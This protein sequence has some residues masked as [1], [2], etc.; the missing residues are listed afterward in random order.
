[1]ILG[2]TG[3]GKELF[4]QS[5]HNASQRKN[6]PLCGHQLRGPAESVGERAVRL[7]GGAFT[8]RP[9]AGKWVCSSRPGGTLFWTRLGKSPGHPDQ[10]AACPPGAGGAAI[11]DDK[12]I[13]VLRII[14]ATNKNLTRLTGRGIL[15]GI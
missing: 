2:E 3:T 12:V 14:S 8:G 7:R 13:S 1:M 11:G 5:I 10:A 9:R 6:G 4:A 15:G